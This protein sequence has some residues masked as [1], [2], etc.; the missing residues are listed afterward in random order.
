MTEFKDLT[1]FSTDL[2]LGDE[3]HRSLAELDIESV[4]HN[5]HANTAPSHQSVYDMCLAICLMKELVYEHPETQVKVKRALATVLD[6]INT[7]YQDNVNIHAVVATTLEMAK[8]YK[9]QRD[10]MTHAYADIVNALRTGD[11]SNAEIVNFLDTY[12]DTI[13][14]GD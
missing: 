6:E 9:Q 8:V 5:L 3:G 14:E 4:L 2:D 7:L 13:A 1:V 11:V 10:E 12:F